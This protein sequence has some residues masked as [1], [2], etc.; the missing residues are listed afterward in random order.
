VTNIATLTALP[1][2]DIFS[3]PLDSVV[4]VGDPASFSVGASPVS[5]C[6]TP[7]SYQWR[8]NGVNIANATDATLN[9][10]SA[11]VSDAGIYSVA[12]TNSFGSVLSTNVTLYVVDVANQVIGSGTGLLGLYYS[13]HLSTA[14]FIGT[15]SWTNIDQ[16]IAFAWLTGAPDDAINFPSLVNTDHFTV[17]WVGQI[18]G[19]WN[20]TY[21]LY[22]T[23]DDGIRLWVNNQLVINSWVNQGGTAE[24]V[25]TVPLTTNLQSILVEFFENTGNAD[26][27]LSWDSPSQVK[28][29]IAMSQLYP[30]AGPP[31]PPQF[32]ATLNNRTNLVF[33]WGPGTY[34]IAWATNVLGPYTNKINA[35]ISPYTVT[36][37][38]EPQRFFRLQVQ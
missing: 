22:T 21:N 15:P 20:Q 30:A 12:I 9:I 34:T 3:Q 31:A 18:Q 38:S 35:V 16:Q 8:H 6:S 11:Q 24:H 26:V 14:P 23:N 19:E 33:N 2:A 17:R 27:A 7:I 5:P 13:N 37:G 10:G 36:I 32:T 1:V 29:V 28:Q 4:N 25:G